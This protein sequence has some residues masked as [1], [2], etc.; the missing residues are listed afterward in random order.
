MTEVYSIPYDYEG[1]RSSI[2]ME[3]CN[4]RDQVAVQARNTG[5]RSYEAPMPVV[6]SRLI[7]A[8]PC[9]FIDIGANTGFYSL[10]AARAGATVLHAF[11]PVPFIAEIL[12]ANTQHNFNEGCEIIQVYNY[13]LSNSI[14]ETFLY[15]PDQR[16]C[17]IETSAS[18][19]PEFRREH[20]DVLKIKVSTLDTHL[21]LEPIS[22]QL[23]L[24]IKID[25]E[26]FEPQVLQ[27]AAKTTLN[28]RP[29]ILLE[30]LPEAD[31]EFYENWIAKHNY[32]HFQLLPPN[33][34][35]FANKIE[36]SLRHRDHLLL[37][38]EYMFPF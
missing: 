20:S 32:R 13:A 15:L 5:W 27:G 4:G 36:A 25:V 19:N 16:H 38:E 37:P 9:A 29:A 1:V 35:I 17:L 12:L 31:L 11:E 23:S 34:V 22:P 33:N 24:L 18:L 21:E 10:I 30:I 6:L 2:Q 26:S 7:G 8:K 14:G 3:A 28:R